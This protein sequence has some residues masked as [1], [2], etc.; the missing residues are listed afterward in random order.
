MLGKYLL[1]YEMVG[2][3]KQKNVTIIFNAKAI[4][5]EV[6]VGVLK[7]LPFIEQ[8][9][10]NVM[11]GDILILVNDQ[12]IGIMDG[13]I[14]ELQYTICFIKR[15]DSILLLNRESPAWMGK[16]NGVGGKIEKDETP[17]DCIVREIEE[18]TGIVLASVAHLSDFTSLHVQSDAIFKGKIT[19]EEVGGQYTGGMYA[20]LLELPEV[21]TYETPRKTEEGILD[22]KSLDWILHE[23]NTGVANLK[24][25]L[26]KLINDPKTYRHRFVYDGDL[27]DEFQSTLLEK[28]TLVD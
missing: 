22:W 23:K 19:W 8:K 12:T 15:G 20:F 10:Y 18:E 27:V 25:F 3:F 16:W 13:V 6:R 9:I 2:L 11:T 24:Y 1:G 14:M 21:F 26:P 5:I 17:Y 7:G 28:T 4:T